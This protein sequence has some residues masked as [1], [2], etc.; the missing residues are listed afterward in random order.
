LKYLSYRLSMRR[1]HNRWVITKMP[2][3]TSLNLTPHF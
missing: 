1:H 3:I 2:T